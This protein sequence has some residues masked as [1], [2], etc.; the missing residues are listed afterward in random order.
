MEQIAI[1]ASFRCPTC[2]Q[3]V[4]DVPRPAM[5]V[6]RGRL[7]PASDGELSSVE[8]RDVALSRLRR[9]PGLGKEG[10]AHLLESGTANTTTAEGLLITCSCG[11]LFLDELPNG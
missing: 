6:S 2:D 4:C 9:L 5:L 1:T 8:R 11:H 3:G 10:L 7:H